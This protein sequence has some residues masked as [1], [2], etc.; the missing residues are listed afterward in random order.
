[1]CHLSREHDWGIFDSTAIRS[2]L[3]LSNHVF[4]SSCS[5]VI[6]DKGPL[7]CGE[8]LLVVMELELSSTKN[9]NH[10]LLTLQLS[11]GGHEDLANENP[12]H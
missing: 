9:L 4:K 7:L 2:E 1:M 11:E 5:K 10:I 6:N 8:D 3:L 12:D